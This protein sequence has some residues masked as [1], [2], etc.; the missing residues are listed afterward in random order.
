MRHDSNETVWKKYYALMR[1]QRYVDAHSLLK[2][3]KDE[4]I[5]TAPNHF[6][7]CYGD[8][9]FRQGKLRD[10]RLSFL[11]SLSHNKT[12]AMTLWALADCRLKQRNLIAVLTRLLGA[13]RFLHRPQL[14]AQLLHDLGNV[15]ADMSLTRHATSC[16]RRALALAPPVSLRRSVQIGLKACCQKNMRKPCPWWFK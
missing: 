8:V 14:R 9:L 4:L 3:E 2:R 10:A 13:L 15:Y 12:D 16:Y 11:H 5:E 7:Y 6:W 1:Q